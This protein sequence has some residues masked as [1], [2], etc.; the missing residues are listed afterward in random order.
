MSTARQKHQIEQPFVTAGPSSDVRGLSLTAGSRL[1][2]SRIA[3]T[4]L[5][6]PSR[7]DGKKEFLKIRN[8]QV[9]LWKCPTQFK[10]TVPRGAFGSQ[11]LK[12]SNAQ[13][14]KGVR[15]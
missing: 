11:G 9:F 3:D 4:M 14:Q 12:P 1:S 2:F 7:E 10:Y 15:S 6:K 5:T 8:Y 13:Q